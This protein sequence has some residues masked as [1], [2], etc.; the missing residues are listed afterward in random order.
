V[1]A[2]I[3]ATKLYI[4]PSRRRVVLRPRLVERLD[5]G[6]AAGNKLTLVSAPAG[7][8]KTTLV[9]KWVAGCGRPTAWLSLDDG[10]SDLS[11]FLTYL[12][13]ALQ[14]VAP[15]VGEAISTV[16]QSPEPPPLESTLTALLNDIATIPRD[17]VL[18]LDDYHVL[19]AKPI[20]DA[21]AFLV[22]NLP[23]QMHLVIT[24]REDPGRR[25]VERRTTPGRPVR[26]SSR[27]PSRGPF[28]TSL[29]QPDPVASRFG[30][31]LR[32]PTAGNKTA[33]GATTAAARAHMR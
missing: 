28:P 33:N 20:D 32:P 7:F 30:T 19:D 18:V 21:V 11:R 15:G 29:A 14:T 24:T 13:A 27:K 22:E 8:G 16:L 3:L 2:P 25:A 9:G 23:P 6:L 1:P 17:A 31:R 4:P 10:D 26:V 5:A 12:I